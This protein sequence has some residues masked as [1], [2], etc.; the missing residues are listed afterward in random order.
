MLAVCPAYD[1]ADKLLA[2]G[3]IDAV[4]VGVPNINHKPLAIASMKAGKDVL[5]EKPMAMN[6]AECKE[7]NAVVKETG[8]I[9]QIGYVQRFS[10]VRPG[11][12]ATD[13]HRRAR[14]GLSRQ[15]T[16]HP[17]TRHPRARRMVHHQGPVRRW[18]P[19]RHRRA[20]HR[21]LALPARRQKAPHASVVKP[22]RTSAAPSR[23][24]STKACGPARRTTTACSMS[25]TKRTP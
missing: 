14:Q 16:A 15:G 13:R 7:I 3:S 20:C 9:L 6:T 2:N 11:R 23:I 24:T 17:P 12:Q 5:L 19:D 8:R 10:T 4:V 21:P 22:T 1:H 25:K 18:T